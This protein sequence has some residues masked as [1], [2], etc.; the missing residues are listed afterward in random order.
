MYSYEY[1]YVYVYIYAYIYMHMYMYERDTSVVVEQRVADLAA[2]L[3]VVVGL[4]RKDG[5]Y[6]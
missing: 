5:L 1:E 4:D 6:V 2:R 3:F